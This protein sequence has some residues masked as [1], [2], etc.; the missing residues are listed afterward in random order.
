MRSAVGRFCT[1]T[2]VRAL[3][4]FAF[5]LSLTLGGLLPASAAASVAGWDVEWVRS[6]A[7]SG[8]SVRLSAEGG[9]L[10]I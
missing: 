5:A 1:S 4:A 7:V 8:P 10:R 3:A 6:P 2:R 9:V